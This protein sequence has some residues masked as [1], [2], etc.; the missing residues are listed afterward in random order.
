MHL[1]Y[2]STVPRG[3]G[4]SHFTK[5]FARVSR[6]CVARC[7]LGQTSDAE[8][9]YYRYNKLRGHPITL[10]VPCVTRG[11]RST[12]Q[13]LKCRK[14]TCAKC[15]VGSCVHCREYLHVGPCEKHEL[16][17]ICSKEWFAINSKSC[18]KCRI[19]FVKEGGCMLV[20]CTGCMH[21][22]CWECLGAYDVSSGWTHLDSCSH[23]LQPG[24]FQ[25]G[26]HAWFMPPHRLRMHG[27]QPNPTLPTR[28][29]DPAWMHDG[30]TP[31]AGVTQPDSVR[32][33]PRMRLQ[34]PTRFSQRHA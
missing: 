32:A 11:C 16:D 14:Y 2:H 3:C 18:P 13:V 4:E 27:E 10:S 26:E 12:E 30:N 25:Q 9:F 6:Q 33:L 15:G 28:F 21:Q 5:H 17:N 1:L 22:F 8:F 24:L 7:I 20:M 23:A 19:P 31:N 29:L 34:T